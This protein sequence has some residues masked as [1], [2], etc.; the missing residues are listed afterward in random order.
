MWPCSAGCGP[1]YR[2]AL[3]AMAGYGLVW[4]GGF[5][6]WLPVKLPGISLATLTV[7]RSGPSWG[8]IG[9]MLA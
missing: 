1:T 6:R 9:P 2:L 3:V 8:R 7:R 5:S 4:L